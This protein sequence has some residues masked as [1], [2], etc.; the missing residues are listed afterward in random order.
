MVELRSTKMKVDLWMISCAWMRR[1]DNR[2]STSELEI[3]KIGIEGRQMKNKVE[4]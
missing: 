1:A 3:V 2:W 4:K